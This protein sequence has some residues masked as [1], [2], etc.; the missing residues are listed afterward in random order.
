MDDRLISLAED[1]LQAVE[2]RDVEAHAG[3]LTLCVVVPRGFP[4][5]AEEAL[6]RG[7]TT[8]TAAGIAA[9]LGRW[10]PPGEDSNAVCAAV[11]GLSQ[12]DDASWG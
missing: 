5:E 3:L 4:P 10:L 7:E 9:A 6:R 11:A 2:G 1:P 8:A 12:K